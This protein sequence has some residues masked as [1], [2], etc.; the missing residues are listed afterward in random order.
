MKPWRR[1]FTFL[2]SLSLDVLWGW[3]AVLVIRLL[4]GEY[5]R[6]EREA[7][8]CQLRGDSWP[9]NDKAW[10]GG[11]YLHRQAGLTPTPWGGTTLSPH[12]I[13]YGPHRNLGGS[14][15]HW[16]PVQQH[17]HVHVEQGE[18]AQLCSLLVGAEVWSLQHPYLGLAT[19]TLCGY[20]L[21]S[22]CGWIIAWLRGESPY[23]GSVHEE[24]AYAQQRKT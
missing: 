17:E 20:A 7:L 23:R 16:S 15:E 18:V 24:S 22:A 2:P 19:W 21:L 9:V 14:P 8:V 1:L 4:W 12:A 13:F 3:P 6:W 10:L 11:W 5:L